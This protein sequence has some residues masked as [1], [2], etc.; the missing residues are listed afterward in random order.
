MA[1]HSG[2]L[3]W[4]IP[5]TQEP[6]G[7]QSIALQ[8]W[9]LQKRL[10]LQAAVHKGPLFSTP[11]PVVLSL[12]FILPILIGVQWCFILVF[13]CTSLVASDV[14]HLFMCLFAL[15]IW[16]KCLFMTFAHFL[17]ELYFFFLLTVELWG[18]FIYSIINTTS[19]VDYVVCKYL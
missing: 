14:E 17:T 9:T 2:I 11:S 5:W 12:I 18:F 6:G 4:R 15:C 1:T 3:A 16:M 19:L 10:S 13:I 7:L 8:S